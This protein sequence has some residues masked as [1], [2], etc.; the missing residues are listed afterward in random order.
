MRSPGGV[1]RCHPRSASRPD[2]HGRGLL[3]V[4]ADRCRI[5]H[6]PAVASAQ[7]VL[8]ALLAD[9]AAFFAGFFFAGAFFAAFFAGVRVFSPR[10]FCSRATKS[11]T[12]VVASSLGARSEE[13]TS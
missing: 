9:L 12:L 5:R 11:T 10:L 1:R 7:A 2:V 8:R 6:V 4:A 3:A 13:H